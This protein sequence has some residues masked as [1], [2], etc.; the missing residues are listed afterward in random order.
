MNASHY[1]PIAGVSHA[2]C[3][4]VR[5]CSQSLIPAHAGGEW[6]IPHKR[7]RE[8]PKMEKGLQCKSDFQ[9]NR[10]ESDNTDCAEGTQQGFDRLVSW[11]IQWLRNE[12]LCNTEMCYP[13]FIDCK[14]MLT[15]L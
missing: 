13:Q 10:S 4:F 7:E 5:F 9:P 15:I 8:K 12:T 1:A 2:G 14:S 11:K 6:N 3:C